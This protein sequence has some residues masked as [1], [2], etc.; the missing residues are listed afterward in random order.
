MNSAS[1]FYKMMISRLYGHLSEN[2]IGQFKLDKLTDYLTQTSQYGEHLFC[3]IAEL[4]PRAKRARVG[5][6]P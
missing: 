4:H 2:K 1:L 6:V 5:G 3:V